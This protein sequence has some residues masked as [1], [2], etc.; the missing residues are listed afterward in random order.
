MRSR[1]NGIP[2]PALGPKQL[3]VQFVGTVNGQN[4]I[5]TLPAKAGNKGDFSI[6][7]PVFVNAC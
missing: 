1:S 5:L 6:P 2:I 3:Q 4:V 7:A